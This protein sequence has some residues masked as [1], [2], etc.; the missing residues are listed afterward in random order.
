MEHPLALPTNVEEALGE[1]L[2]CARGALGEDLR[3][4]VLF[5]SAAENRLR[6]TSDVNLILVL[7]AF[8]LA[9]LDPLRDPLRAAH[10]AV[11]LSV[12]FLREAEVAEAAESFAEKFADVLR[13]RRVLF[14]ADPFAEIRIPRRAEVRRLRQGLLNLVLRG[15]AQDVMVSLR[16]EQAAVA[17]AEFAGP[18]RSFAASLLE[19]EGAPV[20]EPKAALRTL[21]ARLGGGE[22][23][24]VLERISQARE[25]RRLPP[26]VAGSVLR[27]VVELAER[28]H[29]RSLLLPEADP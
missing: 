20:P 18:L 5:G 13:R 17:V 12:M 10:A 21:A 27:R 9:R 26:G 25:D 6:A 11:R 22:W 16:E 2:G 3:S 24:E 1:F 29:E 7:A 23:D 8:D 28:L 19:L 15:R 4:A 14:G